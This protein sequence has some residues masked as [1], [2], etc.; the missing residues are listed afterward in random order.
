MEINKDCRPN[1]FDIHLI[2]RETQTY[3]NRKHQNEF[4]FKKMGLPKLLRQNEQIKITAK[5]L[6]SGYNAI[7]LKSI[8]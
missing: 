3:Y 7:N 6:I 1:I 8:L 2:R 4:R 5:S